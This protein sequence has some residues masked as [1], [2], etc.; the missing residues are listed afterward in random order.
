MFQ[1]ENRNLR[2]VGPS[3]RMQMPGRREELRAKSRV[4]SFEVYHYLLRQVGT[5]LRMS[6]PVRREEGKRIKY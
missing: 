4:Q 3:L 1:P 2:Q 6:M 5:S